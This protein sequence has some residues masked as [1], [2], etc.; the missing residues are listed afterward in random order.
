MLMQY[1]E[2]KRHTCATTPEEI[3]YTKIRI[4]LPFTP[5]R[6]PNKTRYCFL[7]QSVTLSRTSIARSACIQPA[8]CVPVLSV[9][10][11][12]L[13][14]LKGL[15]GTTLCEAPF[16]DIILLQTTSTPRAGAP[17]SIST[18]QP[19]PAL[20]Q[21]LPRIATHCTTCSHTMLCRER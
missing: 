9:H 4:H 3:K 18:A 7:D 8:D 17:H 11:A 13:H 10:M 15:A 5:H 12:L 21:C 1:P 16:P 6:P 19:T 14:R 20:P 2:L